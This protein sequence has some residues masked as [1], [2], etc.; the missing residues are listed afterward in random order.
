MHVRIVGPPSDSPYLGNAEHGVLLG[1]DGVLGVELDG[2]VLVGAEGAALAQPLDGGRGL[3]AEP[4]VVPD[5][6]ALLQRD[7]VHAVALQVRRH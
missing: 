2:G 5:G 6:A 7:V 4:E 3:A 1:V